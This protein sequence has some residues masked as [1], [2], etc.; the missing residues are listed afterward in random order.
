MI[1]AKIIGVIKLASVITIEGRY[2]IKR[3]SPKTIL[4]ISYEDNKTGQE[5]NKEGYITNESPLKEL[6][7]TYAKSLHCTP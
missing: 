7:Y 2:N 1:L 3:F 5:Y 6:S 4:S